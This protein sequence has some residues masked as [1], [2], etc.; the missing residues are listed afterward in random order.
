[1]RPYIGDGYDQE[2]YIKG[3]ALVSPPCR[4]TGRKMAY[5]ETAK[6]LREAQRDS[7]KADDVYAKT[8]AERLTGWSY[9]DEDDDGKW[10]PFDLPDGNRLEITQAT[11]LGIGY[12]LFSRL[13]DIVLGLSPSDED[14]EKPTKPRK[15]G[16]EEK[17]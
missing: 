6:V 14:P 9:K 5:R 13:R 16:D 3:E 8:I 10:K 4:F 1:M 17:N 2:F 12:T 15:S 11:V 7:E